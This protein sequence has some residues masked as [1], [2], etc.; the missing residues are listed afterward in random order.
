MG[1]FRLISL[2]FTHLCVIGKVNS[3]E[4]TTTTTTTTTTMT[5]TTTIACSLYLPTPPPW[6][7][8]GD[9]FD[10]P[11][12]DDTEL[13]GVEPSCDCVSVRNT[14]SSSSNHFC[15]ESLDG[16]AATF[17]KTQLSTLQCILP[18]V[19]FL[20][21]TNEI[22][23]L[24]SIQQ[25][26]TSHITDM[27]QAFYL[28]K[29]VPDLSMWN[30]QSVT[31]S[32]YAYAHV[33][34]PLRL[35]QIFPTSTIQTFSEMF[36]NSTIIDEATNTKT[37]NVSQ[38]RNFRAM[39]QLVKEFKGAGLKKWDVSKGTEFTA[40]FANVTTLEEDISN[41]NV[42]SATNMEGM[43]ILMVGEP[44]GDSFSTSPVAINNTDNG[45]LYYRIG[46]SFN[47]QT[48]GLFC[49]GN[50]CNYKCNPN[51]ATTCAQSESSTSGLA[52][53][54][55]ALIVVGALCVVGVIAGVKWKRRR[56]E[57]GKAGFSLYTQFL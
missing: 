28:L 43:F 3:T 13:I 29:R 57:Q 26:D 33:E 39:F 54:V 49:R 21:P 9:Y 18:A 55:I 7:T 38:G 41:W 31:Y 36:Y 10:C 52:G 45:C 30:T 42:S 6:I 8:G 48:N 56:T 11:E 15:L 5:R 37:L 27:R 44:G 4:S 19:S 53:W 14:T 22:P 35:S 20:E 12:P 32:F 2:V 46:T 47:N 34:N 51:C 23:D 24:D 17:V 25:W 1:T 16:T 50:N 40:M